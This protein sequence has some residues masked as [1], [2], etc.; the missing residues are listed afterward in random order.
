MRFRCDGVF[1][2]KDKSD[3]DHCD[4]IMIDEGV[5]NK[6][7]PPRNHGKPVDVKVYFIIDAIQNI[8]EIDMTFSAKF[9][10]SLEWFD[11]RLLFS[12]LNDGNFSNLAAPEKIEQV[13]IPPLIF[14]NTKKNIMIGRDS[15]AGLF[16]NKL[17]NPRHS[18]ISSVDENFYFDGAENVLLYRMDL[19]LTCACNFVLGKYPFD[20][21]TCEIEVSY[22]FTKNVIVYSNLNGC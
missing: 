15:T 2:C 10:I 18:D 22:Y 12:N 3:E 8:K 20:K 14:N 13:W 19:E 16:I 21:Q 9:T 5:Y 1:Q 6:E 7:F 17:G 11:E 4:V